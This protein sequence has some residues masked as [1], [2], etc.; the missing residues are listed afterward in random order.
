MVH[1][2]FHCLPCY[3]GRVV[4][5]PAV[6]A[7]VIGTWPYLH[8]PC[9]IAALTAG[10]HVL[11]EARMALNLAEAQ[12]MLAAAR[13][14]PALVAQVVPSPF[15]LAYDATIQ[16]HLARGLVGDLLAVDVTQR[17]GAFVDRTAPMHWRNDYDLSGQNIMGMGIFYEALARWVG[18]ATRVLAAGKVVVKQRRRADTGELASVR[19]PEHVDIL[20]ELDCGAQARLQFSSLCGLAPAAR[21][22]WLFGSEGTLKLDLAAGQLLG[23]RRGD[24][25]LRELPIAPE[26]RGGWRVEAEFIGAIRGTEPVRLTTFLDGVKYMA[27]TDAVARSLASGRAEPVCW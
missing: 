15:T 4:A 13:A 14:H 20:A 10:K 25:A 26:Q 3:G 23:G 22:F 18:H 21:E 5:D 12:A 2:A 6:D 8:A 19:I 24:A 1:I 9:S 27:F 16:A 7:V 11:C 17:G